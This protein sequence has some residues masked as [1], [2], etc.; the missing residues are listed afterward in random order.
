M[1]IKEAALRGENVTRL[2]SSLTGTLR[3]RLRGEKEPRHHALLLFIILKIL[4][5]L[6]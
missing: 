3:L 6:I 1:S 5:S 2:S 4:T